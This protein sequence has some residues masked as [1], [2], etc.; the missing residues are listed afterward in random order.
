MSKIDHLNVLITVC[1]VDGATKKKKKKK[2][3]DSTASVQSAHTRVI[4][5][6][7]LSER[8]VERVMNFLGR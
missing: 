2:K 4:N 3:H 8:E 1:D 5:I 7:R 6:F